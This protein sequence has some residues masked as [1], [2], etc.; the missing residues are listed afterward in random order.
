[1]NEIKFL[2]MMLFSPIVIII[3]LG[4]NTGSL[5]FYLIFAV[6]ILAITSKM[7]LKQIKTL[8]LRLPALYAIV[9][10]AYVYLSTP[11]ARETKLLGLMALG[12]VFVGYVLVFTILGMNRFVI[13]DS[14]N[15]EVS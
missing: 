7:N 10:L 4:T 3:P 6:I 15:N 12:I 2:R 1:M 13:K 11:H 8:Y 5:L 9:Y 14:G